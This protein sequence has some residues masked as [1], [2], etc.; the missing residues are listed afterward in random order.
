MCG[1]LHTLVMSSEEGPS[2]RGLGP[3]LSS[4]QGQDKR[5]SLARWSWASC[6]ASGV[7]LP[8]ERGQH[9]Q[10][11]MI[12]LLCSYTVPRCPMNKKETSGDL[13]VAAVLELEIQCRLRALRSYT[14]P[15]SSKL[16]RSPPPGTSRHG[17]CLVATLCP[18]L[19][20]PHGL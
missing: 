14:L 7:Q 6:K 12:P 11:K 15:T 3:V 2:S 5:I 16:A 1:R 13:A 4:L 10:H 20:Q 17:G 8:P 19:L 9:L 18:T